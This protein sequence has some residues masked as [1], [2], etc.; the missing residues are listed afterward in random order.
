[1]K[2]IH[3]IVA[4]VIENNKFLMVRKVGKNIWTNLGGKPEGNETEEEAL[5]REID[6][7]IHC[8]ATIIKKLGDFKAPAVFDKNTIVKLSSYLVELNGKINLDD[9]ELEECKFIPK[10]YKK[11]GIKMPI[12]IEEQILPF[13][14]KNNYLDW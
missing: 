8:S 5:I 7:E 1:M 12:S 9:P 2:E 6:E 11:L 14:I 13:L 4:I 10:N 3:K